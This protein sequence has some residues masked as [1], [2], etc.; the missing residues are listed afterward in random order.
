[1]YKRIVVYCT[2][3]ESKPIRTNFE[4]NLAVRRACAL[5]IERARL[6]LLVALAFALPPTTFALRRRATLGLALKGSVRAPQ[7]R[8]LFEVL[9]G[10][11]QTIEW[12]VL[13]ET[14]QFLKLPIELRK[15]PTQSE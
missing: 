4:V 14:D 11:L 5:S 2:E 8:H 15:L 13:F 1:M 9:G 6:A 10:R 12:L 7:W 3:S